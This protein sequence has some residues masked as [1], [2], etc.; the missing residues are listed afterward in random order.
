[1]REQPPANIAATKTKIAGAKIDF[2][3]PIFISQN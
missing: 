3:M 1:L 2:L